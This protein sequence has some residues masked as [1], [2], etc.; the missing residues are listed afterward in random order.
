MIAAGMPELRSCEDIHYLRD[1]LLL[2]L[3]DD[4]A[5]KAFKK[6][7]KK[8]ISDFYRRVDNSIHILKHG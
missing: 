3:T 4:A 6:E 1:R 7:I 8:T 5:S 2:T